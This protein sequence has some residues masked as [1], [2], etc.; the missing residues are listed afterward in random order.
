MEVHTRLREFIRDENG[1]L[2]EKYNYVV[3]NNEEEKNQKY[4]MMWLIEKK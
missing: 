3:F 1:L 2:S 4:R